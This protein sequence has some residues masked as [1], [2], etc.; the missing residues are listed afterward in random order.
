MLLPAAVTS[1]S[2]TLPTLRSSLAPFNFK[3]AC[4]FCGNDADS[5]TARKKPLH[6]RDVVHQVMTEKMFVDSIRF[7]AEQRCDAWGDIVRA[8]VD[9]VFDLVAAEVRYHNRCHTYFRCGQ[10]L[11]DDDADDR[12][13]VGRPKHQSANDAFEEMCNYMEGND[14]CQYSISELMDKV[15]ENLPTDVDCFSNK[16][17]KAKLRDRYGDGLVITDLAGKPSV[18]CF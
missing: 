16:T 4:L 14:D 5:K 2:Q 11:S 6:K 17:L 3:T 15:R 12:R 9:S 13:P 7:S 10:I 8:R 18:V 1:S